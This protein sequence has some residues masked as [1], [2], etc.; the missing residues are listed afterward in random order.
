MK[1]INH[2]SSVALVV[3]SILIASLMVFSFGCAKKEEKEIK[4]GAVLPLIGDGAL[5]GVKEKEGIELAVAENNDSGG[6]KGKLIRM[7]FEDSKG[8]PATA[9]SALQKLIT[10]DKVQIV[11]GDAF[12]S[13][14]LAMVP[15]INK[16]KVILMSPTASSPKLSNSSEYFFRVWPSDVAEGAVAAEVAIQRLKLKKLAVLHGNNEYAIGLEDVFVDSIKK[17]GGEIVIIETY[18]EGDSDFRSQLTKI[19]KRSPEGI[20]LSG[21]AK[22]FSKILVQA[23]ELNIKSRFISCGTFHEP[24][25][26]QIAGK[27][28]EGVV[29]VQPYFDRNSTDPK[30]QKFVKTYE[31]RFG[32]EAGIYAAHAYD[33]TNVLIAAMNKG[34]TEI[35]SIKN[36]LNNMKD[37]PG[38]TGKITFVKG[39]M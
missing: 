4:I 23:K 27:A 6:V 38:V 20:Y 12:S 1:R 18:N 13:P 10:Q 8:E 31:N 22:E 24:E 3:I 5:Y 28:A 34:G 29:F 21:Y 2:K 9:V 11:I 30:I 17:L 16:N 14:T 37:F 19:K 7:I 25:I 26:L 15:I 33:A 39:G 32:S 35:N 36:T